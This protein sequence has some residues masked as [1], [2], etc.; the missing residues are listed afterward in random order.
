MFRAEIDRQPSV[1]GQ[2][3]IRTWDLNNADQV[4]LEVR[5]CDFPKLKFACPHQEQVG[6]KSRTE[7]AESPTWVLRR[8]HDPNTKTGSSTL[9][10]SQSDRLVRHIRFAPTTSSGSTRR[11]DQ[12]HPT[13]CAT[14]RSSYGLPSAGSP[15]T[16]GSPFHGTLLAYA[17]QRNHPVS[18]VTPVEQ[19]PGTSGSN[20]IWLWEAADAE[21]WAVRYGD[22]DAGSPEDPIRPRVTWFIVFIEQKTRHLNHA[23]NP[24]HPHTHFQQYD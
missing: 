22:A 16:N 21:S 3:E 11:A 15:H 13:P 17:A 1:W 18:R 19:V 9:V 14:D 4:K 23:I 7:Y 24:T 5:K 8:C 20:R 6:F 10:H 12:N 2:L